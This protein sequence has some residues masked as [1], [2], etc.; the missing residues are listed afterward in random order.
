MSPTPQPRPPCIVLGLETQIGLGLVRELGRA[1]V[2][3][4]G[5][6][7]DP[8]A[9]GLSSRYLARKLVIT[10]PRSP[11]LIAAIVALG[12]ELGPCCLIAVS[13]VNMGWLAQ[14]RHAFGRVRPVVPTPETLTMVLDKQRTLQ[15]AR[16]VGIA[17]PETAEPTSMAEAEALAA[18]FHFPAVLKWKDPNAIARKLGPAGLELLKA[19][20]VYTPAEFLAAAA[21]YQPVGEWPMVQAYCPGTGLGQFFYMHK[22][23]AVRRFQHLRVAEWPPEGGFSSVCDA[24]PLDQHADLQEQS[25]ALLRH[26]GWE[27]VAMV[28]YRWDAATGRAV[29]M[30]ING[31]YWGSFPLAVQCGAG[32]GVISY[33]LES[34]LDMPVLPPVRWGQRCRMVSTELKR[35]VRICLQPGKIVDRTFPVRPVAEVW[36]FVR[37]FFRPGVGYYVWNAGDPQPFYTDVKNLLRKVI[38]R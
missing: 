22:G 2:T 23:Q 13:E 7:Y 6:A 14:N 16:E 10:Q 9:I 8:D 15:A 17:V 38:R 29:L 36:R 30:E 33:A 4:I 24:V 21:R 20:Y 32:F 37:D 1:G 19:E 31:R 28:E 12:E 35:L 26:I 27:G 5:I 3:V 25:I 11:E 34:G 18:R